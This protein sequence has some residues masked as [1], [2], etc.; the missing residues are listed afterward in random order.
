MT[1][2]P[3]RPE[4]DVTVVRGPSSDE[5]QPTIMVGRTP[6]SP[7][8]TADDLASERVRAL[9][10]QPAL[11]VVGRRPFPLACGIDGVAIDVRVTAVPVGITSYMTTVFVVD[12][13]TAY[14]LTLL[15]PGRKEPGCSPDGARALGAFVPGKPLVWPAD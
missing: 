9:A 13:E 6:C 2:A 15:E 11:T 12:A 1:E 8:R 4:R 10:G 14:D 3:A 5:A 7:H